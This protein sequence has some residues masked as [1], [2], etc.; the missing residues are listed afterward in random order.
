MQRSIVVVGLA[1]AVTVVAESA[2]RAAD[3]R[4][5]GDGLWRHDGLGSLFLL[6][7]EQHRAACAARNRLGE[8]GEAIGAGNPVT[9][10]PFQEV[11]MTTEFGSRS[12]LEGML[13]V[14]LTQ[15]LAGPFLGMVLGDLG[16]RVIKIERPR[17]DISRGWGPP[18]VGSESAVYEPQQGEPD[19][20]PERPRGPG[21]VHQL[22]GPL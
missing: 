1:A 10:N 15:A 22:T 16:A 8:S 7:P 14:D 19:L 11:L 2:L 20:Q 12:V 13:V 5:C 18:F 17:R 3:G 21:I 4:R 9:R 6:W